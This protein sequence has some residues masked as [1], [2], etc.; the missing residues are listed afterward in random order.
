MGSVGPFGWDGTGDGE[1]NLSIHIPVI[2][3]PVD[4]Y[5]F[6]TPEPL[7]S[8]N[9][10]AKT[11]DDYET[12]YPISA[13]RMGTALVH[14]ATVKIRIVETVHVLSNAKLL[15][16][17]IPML[18]QRYSVGRWLLDSDGNSIFDDSGDT[19]VDNELRYVFFDGKRFV[20]LSSGDSSPAGDEFT[21]QIAACIQLLK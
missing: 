17:N 2:D 8:I 19:E 15:I 18:R 12:D 10:S 1:A 6:T 9:P 4:V 7:G 5:F 16:N 20:I 11:L 14:G 21:D 13:A 3:N